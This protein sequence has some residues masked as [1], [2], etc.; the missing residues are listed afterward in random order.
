MRMRCI[1][2]FLLISVTVCRA[3]D[4]LFTLGQCIDS[5]E[6]NYPAVN[7]LGLQK[8]IDSLQLAVL[9]A[10]WLPQGSITGEATYQSA[11][12]SLDV[13][14][15]GA[16]PIEPLSKDQYNVYLE[17][18]QKIYDGGITSVRKDLQSLGALID[19]KRVQ[20]TIDSAKTKLVG[21]YFNVLLADRNLAILQSS[22][23]A[24]SSN[25]DQL[26]SRL[27]NGVAMQSQVDALKGGSAQARP[28]DHRSARRAETF[29]QV[30]RPSY[31]N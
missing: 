5:L 13:K 28:T 19:Q 11:V 24:V 12:T 31:R 9:D 6:A 29:P 23:A 26:K 16:P 7:K 22:K 2:L 4:N 25:L 21:Y 8:K 30:D 17:V 15:P 10:D 1:F 14:I 3:Q 18:N 20:I 27:R